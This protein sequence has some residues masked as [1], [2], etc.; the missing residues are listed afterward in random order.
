M[1]SSSESLVCTFHP[2]QLNELQNLLPIE[3]KFL[4]NAHMKALC[5]Q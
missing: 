5:Q 4:E 1:P 2:P 3:F